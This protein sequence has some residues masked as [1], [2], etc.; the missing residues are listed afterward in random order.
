MSGI[1]SLHGKT[2]L[3]S[4]V[5]L[6]FSAALLLHVEGTH[7]ASVVDLTVEHTT[8][9][10]LTL[11]LGNNETTHFI[12]MGNE[13]SS[14]IQVSVPEA[15]QRK[16]V[17]N[18]PL[19]SVVAD[20]PGLG[21]VRWHLPAGAYVSYRTKEGWTSLVVHNPSAIPFKIRLTSIDLKKGTS[22][23]NV[24]LLKDKPVTLP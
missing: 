1:L 6:A 21:F 17:R 8:V 10:G 13:G 14:E 2:L 15:W 16:E 3:G 5:L 7:E 4:M 12:E 22:D 11:S 20:A 24:I 18:V 23:T 9:F 19:K